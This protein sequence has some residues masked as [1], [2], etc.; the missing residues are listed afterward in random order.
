LLL[1]KNHQHIRHSPKTTTSTAQ[2]TNWETYRKLVRDK[3]NLAIKLKESEDVQL[4][5]DFIS[6]QHAAQEATPTR[7][8]QRPTNNI[9]SEIKRFV[10]AKRERQV[11]LAKNPYTR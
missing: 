3:V 10:A 11:H 5:T 8:P 9:P 4:S 7:N 2:L 6:V 1:Q